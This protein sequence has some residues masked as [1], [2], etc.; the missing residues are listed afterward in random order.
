MINIS[1]KNKKGEEKK[2][3]EKMNFEEWYE[4]QKIPIAYMVMTSQIKELLNTAYD[5]G[6]IQGDQD[7]W[8][9]ADSYY[10]SPN[11]SWGKR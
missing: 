5:N 4:D 10:N 2:G 1:G 3:E 6:Y 9:G 8:E 11:L 7:A